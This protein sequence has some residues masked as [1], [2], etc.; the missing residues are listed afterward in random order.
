MK[1]RHENAVCCNEL[2]QKRTDGRK[3]K[4][5]LCQHTAGKRKDATEE[6]NVLAL[7]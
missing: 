2:G 3:S 6:L 1:N 5:R 4:E 7:V